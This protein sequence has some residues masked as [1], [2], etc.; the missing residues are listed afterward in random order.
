MGILQITWTDSKKNINDAI[1]SPSMV[2]WLI[3]YAYATAVGAESSAVPS[4]SPTVIAIAPAACTTCCASIVPPMRAEI[5]GSKTK[6]PTSVSTIEIVDIVFGCLRMRLH[7]A[8]RTRVNQNGAS[9]T[10]VVTA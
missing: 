7:N 10:V 3:A 6:R 4:H 1:T 8:V 2:A 5:P 9:A